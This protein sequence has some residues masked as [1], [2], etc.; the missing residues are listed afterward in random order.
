MRR[1]ALAF[2]WCVAAAAAMAVPRYDLMPWAGEPGKAYPPCEALRGEWVPWATWEALRTPFVVEP[3]WAPAVT[4]STETPALLD[5]GSK[6]R[7]LERGWVEPLDGRTPDAAGRILVRDQTGT[8]R[9]IAFPKKPT[10]RPACLLFAYGQMA[11]FTDGVRGVKA[12]ERRFLPFWLDNLLGNPARQAGVQARF[13]ELPREKRKAAAQIYGRAQ[14]VLARERLGVPQKAPD[15]ALMAAL[16]TRMKA[17][18]LPPL[19]ASVCRAARTNDVLTL[20]LANPT[21]RT[22]TIPALPRVDR[23]VRQDGRSFMTGAPLRLPEA[24][25]YERRALCLRPGETRTLRYRLVADEEAWDA[26]TTLVIAAPTHYDGAWHAFRFES[27]IPERHIVAIEPMLERKGWHALALSQ[28][29][30]AGWR[31]APM[32]EGLLQV[33]FADCGPFE[34]PGGLV[35]ETQAEK[36][37]I[38][39]MPETRASC[40]KPDGWYRLDDRRRTVFPGQT[41]RLT[42]WPLEAA[43]ALAG[44][45][46]EGPFT[47]TFDAYALDPAAQVAHPL[48]A[49]R[50]Y[51]RPTEDELRREWGRR[52]PPREERSCNASGRQSCA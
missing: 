18:D 40:Y 50:T 4:V 9:A 29:V 45:E 36:P 27:R 31:V 8:L 16:R 12:E 35:A 26:E 46:T 41:C 19:P 6:T 47:V 5:D 20:R 39:G 21:R 32:P 33:R 51:A 13:A 15:W 43:R 17:V 49:E 42:A 3:T 1:L 24:E 14:R 30:P 25:P 38:L 7:W 10:E 44:L 34:V 48:H 52:D 2:V 28:T 11:D 22:L 37:L 23:H